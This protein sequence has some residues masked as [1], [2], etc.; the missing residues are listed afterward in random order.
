VVPASRDVVVQGAAAVALAES[1][2]LDAAV[3]RAAVDRLAE[4]LGTCAAPAP[5]GGTAAAGAARVVARIDAGGTVV[6]TSVRVD[7]PGPAVTQAAL[8]LVAPLRRLTFPAAGDDTRG[9]AVEALWGP[10]R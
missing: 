8:C 9:L 7:P 1:R 6:A 4:I 2:G 10:G 3:A 5:D